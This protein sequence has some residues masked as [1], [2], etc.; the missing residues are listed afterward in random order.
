M[1]RQVRRF[2]G[3]LLSVNTQLPDQCRLPRVSAF[4]TAASRASSALFPSSRTSPRIAWATTVSI[5]LAC[6]VI[7]SR[8]FSATGSLV[9]MKRH[10]WHE[11]LV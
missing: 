4:S 5:A 1:A 8:P 2:R 7:T 11:V 10:P 9:E 3:N 6:A